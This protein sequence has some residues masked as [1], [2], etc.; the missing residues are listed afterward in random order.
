MRHIVLAI[1]IIGATG[2]LGRPRVDS[3]TKHLHTPLGDPILRAMIKSAAFPR[4][5]PAQQGRGRHV[6][7]VQD[8]EAQ[9][10]FAL[11]DVDGDGLIRDK[12]FE[13]SDN[14]DEYETTDYDINGDGALDLQEFAKWYDGPLEEEDMK[15]VFEHIDEDGSGFLSASELLKW[16]NDEG[17]GEEAQFI[18]VI[19]R[20]YDANSDGFLDQK[21]FETFMTDEDEDDAIDRYLFTVAD[22]DGDGVVDKGE[23]AA[24]S[25]QFGFGLTEGELE[26]EML[27]FDADGNGVWSLPE[28]VRALNDP[29]SDEE[30]TKLEFQAYDM[31]GDGFVTETELSTLLVNIGAVEL[32]SVAKEL[33]R[34]ADGNGDG[35][36]DFDEIIS[37]DNM[38]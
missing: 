6:R 33:I 18:K 32:A 21:E 24:I 9:E 27:E 20:G 23:Y 19:V 15:A 34:E 22:R 17:F 35:K 36:I 26:G 1:V 29:S 4:R 2:G 30:D 38:I 13:L 10:A 3:S 31:D 37:M 11:Y 16:L 8:Q 14:Y 12:E 5:N 25:S 7:S 28:F